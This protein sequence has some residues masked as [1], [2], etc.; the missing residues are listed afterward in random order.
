MVEIIVA[1]AGETFNKRGTRPM[2]K[3]EFNLK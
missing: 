2:N 3:K 1:H